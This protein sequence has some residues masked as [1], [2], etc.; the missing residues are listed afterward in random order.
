MDLA[1]GGTALRTQLDGEP[2]AGVA[3]PSPTQLVALSTS[4]LLRAWDPQRNAVLWSVSLTDEPGERLPVEVMP[5]EPV[6][7]E[8][9]GE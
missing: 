5:V 1:T 2:L 7:E 6:T 9:L 3:V 8:P 4:G